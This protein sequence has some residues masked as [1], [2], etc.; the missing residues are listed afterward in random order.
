MWVEM[1][2]WRGHKAANQVLWFKFD[3]LVGV[4]KIV[5]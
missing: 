4:D 1:S 3:I 2:V 5:R